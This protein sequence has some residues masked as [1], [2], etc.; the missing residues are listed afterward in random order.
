M[1]FDEKISK[2]L[3]GVTETEYLEKFYMACDDAFQGVP[4]LV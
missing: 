1:A 2:G 3:E 4:T